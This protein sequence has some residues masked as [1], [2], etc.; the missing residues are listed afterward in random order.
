MYPFPKNVIIH[1]WSRVAHRESK[2]ETKY[3]RYSAIFGHDA[4]LRTKVW[5]AA[6]VA[7][8][9]S[10][11][12][13]LWAWCSRALHGLPPPSACC[14][15][16]GGRTIPTRSRARASL[17]TVCQ[18]SVW[19]RA[20]CCSGQVTLGVHVSY[21]M[22]SLVPKGACLGVSAQWG[23]RALFHRQDGLIVC[24]CGL[25]PLYVNRH[26]VTRGPTQK[27]TSLSDWHKTPRQQD[28]PPQDKLR[29]LW[30]QIK[31]FTRHCP[32]AVS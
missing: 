12:G 27:H 22:W 2:A 11:H 29:P 6:Q 21:Y 15:R 4:R 10:T 25:A 1:S 30:G 8:L 5:V 26:C 19:G 18:T 13:P 32:W 28:C 9:M 24:P 7:V 14:A 3:W 17:C 20:N 31:F 16:Q 23:N